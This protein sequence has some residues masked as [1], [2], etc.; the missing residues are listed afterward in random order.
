MRLMMKL[1][2]TR[3]IPHRPVGTRRRSSDRPRKQVAEVPHLGTG[4]DLAPL[5]CDGGLVN[6]II[7]I[8]VHGIGPL[9]CQGANIGEVMPN[10]GR[11]GRISQLR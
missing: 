6:E 9:L 1:R 5:V 2:L 10:I 11:L 7:A 8:A 3:S 4:A